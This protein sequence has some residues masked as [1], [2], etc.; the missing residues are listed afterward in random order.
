MHLINEFVWETPDE[1]AFSN[2]LTPVNVGIVEFV[3]IFI[4]NNKLR[5]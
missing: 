4:Q 5:W 3:M 2:E 1:Y